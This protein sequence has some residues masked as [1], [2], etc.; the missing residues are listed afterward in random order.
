MNAMPFLQ[1][2]GVNVAY[3]GIHAVKE[4]E[5]NIAREELLCVIGPNG[6]GKSTLLGLLSGTL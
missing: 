5:L 6:A 2:L 3:G 1:A 4:V